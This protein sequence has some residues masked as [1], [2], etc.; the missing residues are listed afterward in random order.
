MLI[1]RG[2]EL[3]ENCLKPG[4]CKCICHVFSVNNKKHV[5]TTEE[6]F[7]ASKHPDP[8]GKEFGEKFAISFCNSFF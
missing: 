3:C 1:P 5:L 6:P 2:S 8:E 7:S 4:L